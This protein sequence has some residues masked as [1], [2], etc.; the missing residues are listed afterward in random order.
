MA[1][2]IVGGRVQPET[3]VSGIHILACFYW[4]SEA[5][6]HLWAFV[7]VVEGGQI[8]NFSFYGF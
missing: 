6:K 5:L 1:K 3:G 2:N 4:K 7:K 8:Y